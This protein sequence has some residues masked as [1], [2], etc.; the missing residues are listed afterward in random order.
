MPLPRPAV[1]RNRS[2][3]RPAGRTRPRAKAGR[4]TAGPPRGDRSAAAPGA[5]R[6][7]R[8]HVGERQRQHPPA[9]HRHAVDGHRADEPLRLPD[10]RPVVD[11][12]LVLDEQL[13]RSPGPGGSVSARSWWSR[14]STPTGC[15]F[16]NTCARSRTSPTASTAGPG[17]VDGRLVQREP[18]DLAELVG[19]DGLVARVPCAQLLQHG[20][21]GQHLRDRRPRTPGAG[22][23]AAGRS[24][25]TGAYLAS[26]SRNAQYLAVGWP[27]S[28]SGAS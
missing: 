8:R 9:A 5:R 16:R 27:A 21:Q 1:L 15:R 23:P 28:S 25:G 10:A 20:P 17:H 19:A 6:R 24:A 3:A 14:A 18:L 2:A 26:T 13:E 7:R 4:A 12:P 22:A 11:P